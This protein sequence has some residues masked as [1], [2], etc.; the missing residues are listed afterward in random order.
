MEIIIMQQQPSTTSAPLHE[1]P[2]P[3][4]LQP[5]RDGE[6][7]G[8]SQALKAY[9]AYYCVDG[10]ADT[11]GAIEE[12]IAPQR[13]PMVPYASRTGTKKNLDAMRANGWGLL[14]SAKGVLRTEGFQE[15]MLDNGAWSAYTQGE[16]FDENAFTK[17]YNLLGERAKMVV[18]PDIVAGGLKSLDFSL[19]WLDR[20]A[21]G[22]STL[23]LAVQDG[24][25]PD[26][27]RDLLNPGVGIFVGGT[28]DWKLR[29]AHSWGILA[30]RR[31]CHLHVGRVN[32]AK[33]MLLC[34]AAAGAHSVDGTSASMYS[35]TVAP[36]TAAVNYG[37]AQADFF[38]PNGQD[39]DATDYDC[40]W[41]AD[42]AR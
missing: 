12:R 24:M 26:D 32:S 7:I 19:K 10:T 14:V 2:T 11:D 21:G 41:P 35:K 34:S 16:A 39:F 29:T 42:L 9:S 15:V 30:R 23:L 3:S 13:T 1:L 17:A 22:P 6:R 33:R 25:V 36:L 31:C 40:A 38:S 5:Y 18:V 8:R 20:L 27:V 4:W 37:E 28:S